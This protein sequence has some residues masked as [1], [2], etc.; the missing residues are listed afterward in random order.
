MFGL[1]RKLLGK[2]ANQTEQND[3]LDQLVKHVSEAY[4]GD[5]SVSSA[6]F[7]AAQGKLAQVDGKPIYHYAESHKHDIEMMKRCCAAIEGVYWSHGTMK[8]APEPRYFER[9][10]ILSRK[11]KDYEG[12]I[13]ICRRWLAME[14]DFMDWRQG[15]Q[16]R[17]VII[18]GSPV[19]RRIRE[20]LP[21]AMALLDKQRSPSA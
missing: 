10:A 1:F 21:K 20:R 3:D 12:E 6:D 14:D 17:G 19:A 5:I 15:D 11:A 7:L 13:D 2:P 4:A 18:S 8:M 16:R 9:V